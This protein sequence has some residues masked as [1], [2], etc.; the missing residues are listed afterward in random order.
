LIENYNDRDVEIDDLKWEI[1]DLESDKDDLRDSI[2]S[3]ISTLESIASDDPIESIMW[4]IKEAV[5][6]LKYWL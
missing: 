1:R 5:K 4:D 6:E 3:W 2:K